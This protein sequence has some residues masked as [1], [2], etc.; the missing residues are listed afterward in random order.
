M[1]EEI[2]GKLGEERSEI[3]DTDLENSD[4]TKV[5][6]YAGIIAGAIALLMLGGSAIIFAQGAGCAGRVNAGLAGQNCGSAVNGVAATE[7]QA[8]DASL[9][10]A[11]RG[12]APGSEY[13]GGGGCCSDA[14]SS[15]NNQSA[16]DTAASKDVG[17]NPTTQQIEK[18]ATEWYAA[19]FGDSKVT[20]VLQDF[21]CHQQISI[22]KGQKTVKELTYRNGVFEALPN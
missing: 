6:K 8:V 17:N 13:A 3:A 19:N 15:Y 2:E 4:R 10:C 14:A 9:G 16:N 21:G 5:I 7:G 12:A 22:K 20:A 11:K 18:A 1:S